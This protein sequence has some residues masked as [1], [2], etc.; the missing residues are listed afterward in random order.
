MGLF[1]LRTGTIHFDWRHTS[2]VA[3]QDAP[4]FSAQSPTSFASIA[5]PALAYAGNLWTWMPQVRIE[6]RLALSENSNLILQGGI[7]DGLTGEPPTYSYGRVPQAGE[8]SRQPA[9]AGRVAWSHDLFGQPF[10]LGAGGYYSRQNWGFER[11]V[12]AWAGTV[13]WSIPF[14]K[15]LVL[16]G[17]FYRGQGLGGL[18]GGSYQSA[19]FTGSPGNPTSRAQGLQAIGGWTQL[20]VRASSKLEFNAAAGQDNPFANEI[21]AFPFSAY[22]G[23]AVVPAARNQTGLL[24][25]IFRPRSDLLLSAEYG[26]IATFQIDNS[27]YSADRVSLVMGIMF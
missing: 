23:G 11:N 13:D 3:G 9:Y 5:E 22:R 27:K 19:L 21:R 18:G 8:Y 6:H 25:F 2:I 26:H 14:T 20:K 15:W 16:N 10:T 7:L 1:R 4:F 12:D 17:E 24:N